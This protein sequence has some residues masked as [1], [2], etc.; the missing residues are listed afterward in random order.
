LGLEPAEIK[1]E[2]VFEAILE[3]LDESESSSE[4][5]YG[6]PIAYKYENGVDA[7]FRSF[8]HRESPVCLNSFKRFIKLDLMSFNIA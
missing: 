5:G 3:F 8:N 4:D 2:S 6:I 7:P 1:S